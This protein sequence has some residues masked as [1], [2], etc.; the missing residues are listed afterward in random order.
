MA[1]VMIGAYLCV[2][3]LCVLALMMTVIYGLLARGAGITDEEALTSPDL[4]GSLYARARRRWWRI[5]TVT[6]VICMMPIYMSM[7]SKLMEA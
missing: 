3:A 5:H 4:P 1:W 6:F 2:A 7:C